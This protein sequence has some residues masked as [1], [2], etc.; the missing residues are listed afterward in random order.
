MV[1]FYFHGTAASLMFTAIVRA[2]VRVVDDPG[3]AV[4]APVS[5]GDVLAPAA[6]A[7]VAVG[8]RGIGHGSRGRG[9][10]A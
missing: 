8:G 2:A 10:G 7:A 1:V 4:A 3:V 5:D 6:A 9:R